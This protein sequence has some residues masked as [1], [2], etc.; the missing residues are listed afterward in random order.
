MCP[1][2]CTLLGDPESLQFD[3]GGITLI[4]NLSRFIFAI[5]A[6]ILQFMLFLIVFQCAPLTPQWLPVGVIPGRRDDTL[7]MVPRSLGDSIDS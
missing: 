6:V 2:L 7:L 3:T 1:D 4:W 5:P